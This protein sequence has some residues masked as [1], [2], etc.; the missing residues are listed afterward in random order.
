MKIRILTN[1]RDKTTQ[2]LHRQLTILS[3]YTV[4]FETIHTMRFVQIKFQ[5]LTTIETE[6]FY[7]TKPPKTKNFY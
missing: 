3:L 2:E 5:F 6:N 7:H 4:H 1:S